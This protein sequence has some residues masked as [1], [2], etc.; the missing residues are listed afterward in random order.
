MFRRTAQI[1]A[2]L[3]LIVQSVCAV[4]LDNSKFSPRNRE[5]PLRQQTNFIIL[6]TTE[7]PSESSV[8]KLSAN[9]EC[10][11]MIDP[12]GRIYRVIDSRRVAYHVGVSMW[13]GRVNLDDCSIGIEMVGYHDKN[14]SAQQYASL[15]GLLR[16]LKLQYKIPDERVMPH[17]MVAYGRPNQWQKRNHRGR[18]QCGMFFAQANVRKRLGLKSR[19]GSDPDVRAGRLM[20]A[21]PYLQSVLFGSVRAVGDAT[22]SPASLNVR[23]TPPSQAP[24]LSKQS[25]SSWKKPSKSSGRK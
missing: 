14:L 11:Y 17:S 23:R 25:R 10:H 3:L 1:A 4:T 20:V 22:S 21:D 2:L 7:A 15:A 9:G 5:R 8:N 24:V 13:N 12:Y 18:K 16:E 6:H 19:Q